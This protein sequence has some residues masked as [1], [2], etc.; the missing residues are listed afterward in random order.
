MA[1]RAHVPVVHSGKKK[2]KKRERERQGNDLSLE[3]QLGLDLQLSGLTSG[4]SQ[5]QL[6]LRR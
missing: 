3:V 5:V 6:S 4:P 2:G 1:T